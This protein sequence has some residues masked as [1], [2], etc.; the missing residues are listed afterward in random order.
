[1]ATLAPLVIPAL[2]KHTAS[3]IWAHGLGDQ[4]SGWAPVAENFRLRGKFDEVSFI[5]PN[6]PVSA[7]TRR[8][9]PKAATGPKI[10]V[11][12]S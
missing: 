5:F 3:V 7:K 12:F 4:G 10:F 6:A 1:M 9:G 8:D 11:E 2:K